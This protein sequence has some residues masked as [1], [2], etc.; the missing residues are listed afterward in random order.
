MENVAVYIT[1]TPYDYCLAKALVL[2]VRHHCPQVSLYLL[3]EVLSEDCVIPFR[4]ALLGEICHKGAVTLLKGPPV[5]RTE[6]ELRSAGCEPRP[7]NFLAGRPPSRF[8]K[9][10]PSL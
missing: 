10:L 4:A 5:R 3:P 1:T 8:V 2:C 7:R 6:N 9:C